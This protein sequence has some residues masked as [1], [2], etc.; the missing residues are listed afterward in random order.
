MS[1]ITTVLFDL[2]GTLLPMDQDTF[3]KAYFGRLAKKLAPHGYETEKLIAAIWEG[4][5]SMV[6]NNGSQTNEEVFWASFATRFG[7][8]VRQDEPLFDEY[9]RQE[10]S[11]VQ[12]SCG[13]TPR[14]AET[15]AFLKERGI[16]CVL[17]TNPI[18]PA[19]ATRA[20]MAWAGLRESDFDLVT[21]YENSRHCKP[22]PDYYKDI[23]AEL[24]LTPEECIM[25][26]NDATE[27][28]AAAKLGIPVFLVTDCLI[29]KH[30]ADLSDV[31]QGDFDDLMTY[32]RTA[33]A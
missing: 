27:D 19:V 26:G 14:A 4:T 12:A 5:A 29:N 20:R 28:L 10:F 22:N 9:Y 2:D 3:V 8:Q 25:V 23:L 11:S 13:F 24:G 15:V 7:E 32:L 31:P 6:R 33:L 21:T 30:Q 16:R 18:F 17:A 1:N